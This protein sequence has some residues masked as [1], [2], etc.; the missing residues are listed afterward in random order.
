MFERL[1]RIDA[2][3]IITGAKRGKGEYVGTQEMLERL[4]E[5]ENSG[6]SPEE[7]TELKEKYETEKSNGEATYTIMCGLTEEVERLKKCLAEYEQAKAEGRLVVLPVKVG[8][9]VWKIKAVFS[10]FSKPIEDRVERIIISSNEILV[11]CTSGTK[12]SVNSIGKTVF[13]T[14][15]EAEKALEVGKP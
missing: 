9:V 15:E 14:R 4:Y 7:V 13:L 3:G 12:F 11:C 1:T 2:G 8:D 6:L 5:Y 10:Y